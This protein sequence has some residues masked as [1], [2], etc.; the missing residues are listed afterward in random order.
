MKNKNTYTAFC[1]FILSLG[2]AITAQA[3]LEGRLPATPGGTDYQAYYDT[4][5]DITWATDAGLS[6]ERHWEDQNL[7]AADFVLD[8]VS[9]WRLP[10][11][12]EALHLYEDGITTSTPSPFIN[13]PPGGLEFYWTSSSTIGQGHYISFSNGSFSTAS[14][15]NFLW[16]WPVYSG[17]IAAIS[18]EENVPIPAIALLIMSVVIGVIGA[19]KIRAARTV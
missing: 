19:R 17:D 7:W 8:G 5:L 18:V 1:T 12:L 10:S 2:F 11:I 6:I 4:D 14:F 13:I 3:T 9:G 15:T 16:G